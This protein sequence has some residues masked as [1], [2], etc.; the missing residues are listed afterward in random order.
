MRTKKNSLRKTK[1]DVKYNSTLVAKL[2]NRS[3]KSG[4]KSVA[5]KQVY[6]AIGQIAKKLKKQPV[7]IVEAVVEK[8][9]PQMEVRTRRVGGASYQVPVPVKPRR[10][11]SL[12]VRWLVLEANKRS[13]KEYHTYAQKLAAEIE[14][15]LNNRGGA[16][17]R[18]NTSH[19][20]AEANKA[21][22][23]FRW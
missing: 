14:D 17:D 22:A 23:H 8:V 19:R 9:A 7:E 11:A 5:M 20:M 16:I 6:E 13:N 1:P 21:F 10:G 18:R 4:K 2:I 12:A 3:M 15:A